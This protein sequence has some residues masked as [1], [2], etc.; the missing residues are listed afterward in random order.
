VAN[1]RNIVSYLGEI[2]RIGRS[3]RRDGLR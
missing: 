3:M 1:L 2:W